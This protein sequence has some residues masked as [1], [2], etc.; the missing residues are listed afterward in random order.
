M[1][2][3]LIFSDFAEIIREAAKSNLAMAVL[4]CLIITLLV[5]NTIYLASHLFDP[6]YTT[7]QIRKEIF[8][9][10]F[11]IV[12]ASLFAV[13]IIGTTVNDD[14]KEPLKKPENRNLPSCEIAIFGRCWK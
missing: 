2:K 10:I 1:N 13:I 6:R 5:G 12:V 4:L 14:N 9:F 7:A 3:F 11:W 8:Q